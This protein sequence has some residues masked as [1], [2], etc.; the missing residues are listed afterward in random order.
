[1]TAAKRVSPR[2]AALVSV[3]FTTAVVVLA[4][5][6]TSEHF[7]ARA[8]REHLDQ[9]TRSELEMLSHSVREHLLK[10]QYRTVEEHLLFWAGRSNFVAEVTASAPNGFILARYKAQLPA[11]QTDHI[12]EKITH[13]GRLLLVLDVTRDLDLVAA[14]ILAHRVL[15]AVL[16]PVVSGVLGWLLWEVVRRSAI[17]PM[18]RAE[19]ALL[20]HQADLQTKVRERTAELEREVETR[21]QTEASLAERESR[22]KG[23]FENTEVSIWNEDMSDLHLAL[24]ELR[25]LGVHDLRKYLDENP[26]AAWEL[27]A[28][29][30]I[31]HVNQATL[32][33]FGAAAEDQFL[34]EI[35][36]TFGPNTISVFVDELCAI[37]SGADV[38]RAEAEFRSLDG[39]AFHALI[40]YRIPK[41]R[42][43]F[44][45]IPVSI[46]DI[47]D[48]ILAERKLQESEERFRVATMTAGDAIISADAKG[49]ITFWNAAAERIFGY[50]EHQIVGRRISKLVPK[51][52][53]SKH[54][55]SFRRAL[56]LVDQ[57]PAATG[58]ESIGLH[59][60]GREMPVEISVSRWMA[61]GQHHFT[62]I[63]RD[64]S[65][66][67]QLEKQIRRAQK[68]EA[69]GQ[70]TGGISHDF[71]NKLGVIIGNLDLLM[72]QIVENP[73]AQEYAEAA[74]E[75]AERAAELTR[76][77]LGFSRID[78]GSA[79]LVNVNEFIGGM[80][81]L[82]TRSLTAAIAVNTHLASD[83]WPVNVD[84]G[85]F[86]DM[87][88]NLALKA[89]DAMPNGG[90]LVI[91]SANKTLDEGY[92]QQTPG[93]RTGDHVVI[94]VSDTGC[95]MSPEILDQIFEPFFTT[96]SMEQG[97]GLGLAMVYGFVQR[98]RGHIKVYSEP[99]RGTT[100]RIYLPRADEASTAVCLRADLA[101][102]AA[103]SGNESVLVVDDEDQLRQAAVTILE[104]LGYH[105][106]S[107]ANG[108]QAL[109]VLD[110]DEPVDLVFSDVV[111][112][113]GIDGYEL[114]QKA[115]K[116]HPGLKVLL[117]T[118]FAGKRNDGGCEL[119]PQLFDALSRNCLAK[120]Y[121]R[122]ELAVAIR[123]TLD[124]EVANLG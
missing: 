45:N 92:V 30:K 108:K 98:S 39:R 37:W 115:L 2:K 54:G 27:A 104:G 42:T 123:K 8:E 10:H 12:I 48:R 7:H 83:I 34:A 77:L 23:L 61:A 52:L 56:T 70:L 6:F 11:K 82:I 31:N 119:D 53:R 40:Y 100:I 110:A 9:Q 94:S 46:I 86:E 24:E 32:K 26:G 103:P 58:I 93:A 64:I 5:F 122:H 124:K 109:D 69:V 4:S 13:Q 114:A 36:N 57:E 41:V 14:N 65:E 25:G 91:E 33:L 19:G 66:R 22:S 71:N 95:G 49:R 113:G 87:L 63:I 79:S 16:F 29:V 73:V 88:L 84:P 76:K 99:G 59:K 62:A 55:S 67:K 38:F 1:M 117:A 21:R 50:A 96:K 3:F 15:L 112:P 68:M 18:E 101:D 89:R 90:F 118:G 20:Q 72:G 105:T 51:S 28:R 60:D 121:S 47:S 111:M 97:T 120:P 74:L 80:E 75:G 35:T 85:D 81:H 78:F 44:T 107:V 43:E 116:D 102:G 106:L 17:I